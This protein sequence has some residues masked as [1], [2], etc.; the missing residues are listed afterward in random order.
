M[1]LHCGGSE[2]QGER[3]FSHACTKVMI[4]T[5]DDGEKVFALA[6]ASLK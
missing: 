6:K 1:S 3:N 2:P 4:L 5:E